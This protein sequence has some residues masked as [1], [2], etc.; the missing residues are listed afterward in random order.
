MLSGGSGRD[1]ISYGNDGVKD[2][3][4]CGPGFDMVRADCVDDLEGCE[5]V[6]RR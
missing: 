2:V 6:T 4:D 5:N 1:F 3:I